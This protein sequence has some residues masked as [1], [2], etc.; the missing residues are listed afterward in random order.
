MTTPPA[1]RLTTLPTRLRSLPTAKEPKQKQIEASGR[2][3]QVPFSVSQLDSSMDN[4]SDLP[5]HYPH[6]NPLLRLALLTVL[7]FALATAPLAQADSQE[8][9]P[10]TTGQEKKEEMCL[11][12]ENT[13]A[14]TPQ[15]PSSVVHY[16]T[17]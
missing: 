13:R 6:M 17:R 10:V 2:L 1:A 8:T 12:Q 7:P 4:Q 15:H 14:P 3:A 16:G 9:K 5:P 11:I